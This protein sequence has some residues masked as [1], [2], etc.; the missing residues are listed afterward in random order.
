[1]D[2]KTAKE[3]EQMARNAGYDNRSAFIRML[4]RFEVAENIS[5]FLCVGASACACTSMVAW[6]L[7]KKDRQ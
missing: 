6:R 2:Q 4:I 3:L 7:N 5:G 1:M